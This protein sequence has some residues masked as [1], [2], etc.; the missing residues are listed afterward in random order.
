MVFFNRFKKLFTI[1]FIII[2]QIAIS[3]TSYIST[4]DEIAKV[5]VNP[6][7]A[8]FGITTSGGFVAWGLA[9]AGGVLTDEVKN[10]LMAEVNNGDYVVQVE[11]TKEAFTVLFSSGVVITWGSEDQTCIGNRDDCSNRLTGVKKIYDNGNS[12]LVEKIDGTLQTWG[13]EY[14]GGDIEDG[15]IFDP[16]N[17][18]I[19]KVV[20]NDHAYAVLFDDGS[21]VSWGDIEDIYDPYWIS[22]NPYLIDSGVT[23]LF[24]YGFGFMA[25]GPDLNPTVWGESDLNG[26]DNLSTL[27]LDNYYEDIDYTFYSRN[28]VDYISAAAVLSSEGRVFTWGSEYFGN[29]SSV[30]SILNDPD[31]GQIKDLKITYG[32]SSVA[33]ALTRNNEFLLW[34]MTTMNFQVI[35]G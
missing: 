34:G 16:G 24:A 20:T 19:V 10:L 27:P 5:Y 12:F 4:F 6:S 21:V 17:R 7:G 26:F 18:E 9:S 2:S 31:H 11:S 28:Y 30:S 3:Q 15:G 1:Q 22:D 13:N 35:Q 33:G 32:F 25:M 23:K 29:S 8:Y 14:Y